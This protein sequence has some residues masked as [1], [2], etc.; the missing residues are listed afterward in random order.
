MQTLFNPSDVFCLSFFG[1]NS[2]KREVKIHKGDYLVFK[3][4]GLQ[5]NTGDLSFKVH[6]GL[7]FSRYLLCEQ[8]RSVLFRFIPFLAN[9]E[10]P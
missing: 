9:A 6:Y 5:S 3:E 8:A 7:R 2:N 4:K 1:T 10:F